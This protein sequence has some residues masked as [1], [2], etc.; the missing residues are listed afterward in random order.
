MPTVRSEG[1]SRGEIGW[2]AVRML[3]F[4]QG[5]CCRSI[6]VSASGCIVGAGSWLGLERGVPVRQQ[7][8]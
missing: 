6:G 3:P 8:M 1:C 5:C 4:L 2:G 7:F